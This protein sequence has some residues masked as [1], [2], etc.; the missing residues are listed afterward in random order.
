[1][2]ARLK[3]IQ[4]YLVIVILFNILFPAFVD[5]C[6]LM[7]DSFFPPI[8]NFENPEQET[9]LADYLNKSI[10][11]KTNSFSIIFLSV[12]NLFNLLSNS[13]FQIACLD[14]ETFLLRC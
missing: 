14:Q 12:A 13:F 7:K 6:D 1:V 4:I 8:L 5:Y 2:K 10:V 9:V 11:F 3:K